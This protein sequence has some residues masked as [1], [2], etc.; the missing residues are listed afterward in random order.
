[1]GKILPPQKNREITD[2]VYTSLESLLAD[3][4]GMIVT[5]SQR[6]T[7]EKGKEA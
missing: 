2:R 4:L 5:K 7:E 1:M 3:Q 6:V